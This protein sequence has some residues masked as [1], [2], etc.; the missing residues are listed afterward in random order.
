MFEEILYFLNFLY[1][2]CKNW[3]FFFCLEFGN[4]TAVA[5]MLMFKNDILAFFFSVLLIYSYYLV[6][7]II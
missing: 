5:N 2:N 3:I 1:S 4:V 6:A 7:H